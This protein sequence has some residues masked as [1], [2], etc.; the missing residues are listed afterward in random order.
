MSQKRPAAGEGL[1]CETLCFYHGEEKLSCFNRRVPGEKEEAS[2]RKKPVRGSIMG[3]GGYKE[4]KRWLV[5][6]K[7]GNGRVPGMFFVVS[8]F[9]GLKTVVFGPEIEGCRVL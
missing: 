8:R 2:T 9:V 6:E 5:P 7:A 4:Q 3:A 1:A